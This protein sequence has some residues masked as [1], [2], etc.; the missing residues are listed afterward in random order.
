MN[1]RIKKKHQFKY[2]KYSFIDSTLYIRY[3]ISNYDNIIKNGKR[4]IHLV[5]IGKIKH[6]RGRKVY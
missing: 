4:A 5:R 6:D 1:K 3:P 2:P